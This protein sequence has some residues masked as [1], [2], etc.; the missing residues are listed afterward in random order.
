MESPKAAL[1]DFVHDFYGQSF[2]VNRSNQ[3]L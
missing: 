1:T 3:R 2:K